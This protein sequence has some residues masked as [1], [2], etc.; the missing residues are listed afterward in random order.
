MKLIKLYMSTQIYTH[1]HTHKNTFATSLLT[2]IFH[3]PDDVACYIV[4][5]WGVGG[6]R[7]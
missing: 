6:E 2:N 1:T 4:G 3:L 7:E 5:R